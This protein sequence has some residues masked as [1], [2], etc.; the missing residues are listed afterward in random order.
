MGTIRN[1]YNDFWEIMRAWDNGESYGELYDMIV[2]WIEEYKDKLLS[3][4]A[5]QEANELWERLDTHDEIKDIVE[6]FIHG[7]R[8][9]EIRRAMVII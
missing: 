3:D 7:D 1:I 5:K 8:Y 2:D 9:T 6:D 4:D